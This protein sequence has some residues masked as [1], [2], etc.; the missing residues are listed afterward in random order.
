MSVARDRS[1]A[2]GYP[3]PESGSRARL[4]A[5]SPVV[6][7]DTRLVI[8][9]SFPGAASLRAGQYYAHPR[10]QFWQILG[11]LLG[12]P[13][14]EQAYASRIGCLLE[15]RIG[16]WDVY[17]SCLREGSLDSAIRDA[18]PN[19]LSHLVAQVPALRM[20]IHNGAESARRMRE[21][22]ALGVPAVR[23]PSTSPANARLDLQAKLEPWR[24][25]LARAGVLPP[26]S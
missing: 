5:L 14:P 11:R 16:L 9:G 7:A 17:A 20:V 4:R 25:A 6:R 8:L 10:N 22:E 3:E 2:P 24:E 26:I 13:L 21:V 1:P 23:L 19:D 12:Q 15:H 18:V